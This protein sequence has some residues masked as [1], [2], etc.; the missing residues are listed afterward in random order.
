MIT[1]KNETWGFHGT[2]RD[3]GF[4]EVSA[5]FDQ[6]A[7][8]LMTRLGLTA[9]EARDVLDAPIGRHMADDM[10]ARESGA[11]LVSRWLRD[12]KCARAIREA[13]G[14]ASRT[15][16]KV[17]PI[18]FRGIAIAMKSAMDA[19]ELAGLA[20][21]LHD[22]AAHLELRGD[23]ELDRGRGKILARRAD[24]L[25]FLADAIEAQLTDPEV[26]A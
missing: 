6:A 25:G 17:F 9:D 3:R 24:V 12:R 14:R 7:H 10:D 23:E 15:R 19:P 22:A 13:A 5:R 4:D 26:P 1:T 2:L 20:D 16:T 21:R 18:T 8:E 11:D